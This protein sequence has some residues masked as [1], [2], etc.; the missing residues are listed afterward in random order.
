MSRLTL[1]PIHNSNC[2][3]RPIFGR[4]DQ[5]IASVKIT[6]RERERF[7]VGKAGELWDIA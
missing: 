2:P 1:M 7:I 3:S 4:R 5:E 6:M